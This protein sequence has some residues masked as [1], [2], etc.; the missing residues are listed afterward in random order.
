MTFSIRGSK[1]NLKLWTRLNSKS[2]RICPKFGTVIPGT[3]IME[4]CFLL[5]RYEA[6]NWAKSWRQSSKVQTPSTK[7]YTFNDKKPS[8][9]RN[10]VTKHKNIK[11]AIHSL[12]SISYFS[13][14]NVPFYVI[15]KFDGEKKIA[16]RDKLQTK[17]NRWRISQKFATYSL[18]KNVPVTV[19]RFTWAI[20]C[21]DDEKV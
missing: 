5:F 15:K 21:E 8:H 2:Y 19:L 9:W 4:A 14:N 20:M 12:N 13:A 16:K 17:T 1:L 11:R 3:K 10:Y 7:S 6:Q 18:G